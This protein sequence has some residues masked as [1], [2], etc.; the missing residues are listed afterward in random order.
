MHI[1]YKTLSKIT[2]IDQNNFRSLLVEINEIYFLHALDW[3][4]KNG[5][6]LLKNVRCFVN[7]LNLLFEQLAIMHLEI[8]KN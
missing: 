7:I 5:D 6:A 3:H 4:A 1:D 2:R 8:E